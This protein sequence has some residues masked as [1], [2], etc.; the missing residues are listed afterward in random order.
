MAFRAPF[1]TAAYRCFEIK[2]VNESIAER[3][4]DMKS[5]RNGIEAAVLFVHSK[6]TFVA[7][8]SEDSVGDVK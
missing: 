3:K 1:E 7:P 5:L 4:F 6:R 8:G 2:G